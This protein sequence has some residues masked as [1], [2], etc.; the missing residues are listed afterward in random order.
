MN[1]NKIIFLEKKMQKNK[2]HLRSC[3][4]GPAKTFLVINEKIESEIK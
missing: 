4:I 1:N 2:R 3:E